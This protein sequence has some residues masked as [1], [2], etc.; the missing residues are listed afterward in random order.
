METKEKQ[1]LSVRDYAKKCKISPQQ[2]YNRIADGELKSDK[3]A[4]AIYGGTVI[5]II[6]FPVVLKKKAGRKLLSSKL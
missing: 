2:V 1:F 4:S 5:D 6:A 3:N